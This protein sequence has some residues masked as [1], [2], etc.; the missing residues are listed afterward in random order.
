MCAVQKIALNLSMQKIFILVNYITVIFFFF[1]GVHN[2]IRI[3]YKL[4]D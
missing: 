1:L 3:F 4:V 2:L